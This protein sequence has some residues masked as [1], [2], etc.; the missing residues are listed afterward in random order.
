M[1]HAPVTTAS[2]GI[3]WKGL[4]Y[5]VS[6]VSVFLLGTI[7][8]PKAGE[9]AW[10]SPVLIAGMA[11]SIIGMGF[12]YKAHLAQQRELRRTEAKAERRN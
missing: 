2:K 3:D 10:H 1:R 12:R 9:P 7:A 11:T 6:I 4:G 8:W 5:I